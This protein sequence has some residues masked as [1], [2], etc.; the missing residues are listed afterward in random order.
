[1][2]QKLLQLLASNRAQSLKAGVQS[3]IVQAEGDDE[4]TVY[5]YDT[6]VGDRLTAEYWGG[7]C[8]QDFVPQIA[9]IKASKINLRVNSPGGDVFAA[10]AMCT[11]LKQ[12]SAKITAHIDGIAASAATVIACACDEVIMSTGSMYMIHN[13]WTFAMGNRHDLQ[14]TVDLMIKIDGQL[15]SQYASKSGKPID[16]VTSWMDAE[17]WF[18]ADEALAAGFVNLIA[19]DADKNVSA[20]AARVWDLSAYANSAAFCAA[21]KPADTTA[22]A[23]DDHRA[24]QQQRLTMSALTRS[25]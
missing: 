21:A 24:R 18:T 20:S 3:R 5:L 22:Y 10:Q 13:A 15:A 4:A 16:Q 14:Q 12:H 25:L 8:A 9:A 6:I 19:V 2:N 23:A 11:A 7:V 17:T 1:M